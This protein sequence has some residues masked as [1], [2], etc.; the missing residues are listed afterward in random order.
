MP[1]RWG[2]SACTA[3]LAS[4]HYSGRKTA[5]ELL[6][7]LRS[8]PDGRVG[9]TEMNA[10]RLV[11]R[12]LVSALTPLVAQLRELD[13]QIASAVREHPDGEIFLS[14]FKDPDSFLTAAELVAEIGDSRA[15]YPTRDALAGDAGQAAV[16]RESGK[17]KDA[18]RLRSRAGRPHRPQPSP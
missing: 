9:E 10:R 16:A 13:R 17:R 11:V 12:S 3:F 8:A 18:L 7:R 6:A 1:A 15:R 5:G 2:K 14:L 4:Q